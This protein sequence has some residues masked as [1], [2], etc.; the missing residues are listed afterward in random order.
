MQSGESRQGYK[1]SVKSSVKPT[2]EVTWSNV[3]VSRS[4]IY[5][6]H[7][8][9]YPVQVKTVER[10]VFSPDID[11][12][13]ASDGSVAGPTLLLSHYRHSPIISPHCR[14]RQLST[15]AIAWYWCVHAYSCTR[16][17]VSPGRKQY[18]ILS[19]VGLD[20]LW[21]MMIVRRITAS[22]HIKL[23]FCAHFADRVSGS[24]GAVGHVCVFMSRQ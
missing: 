15:E 11:V 12:V 13:D 8:H 10:R 6:L 19:L 7:Q 4:A 22:I 16:L 18:P 24:H 23:E 1:G 9:F 2:P 3:L 20:H 5:P 14:D 21:E 17:G